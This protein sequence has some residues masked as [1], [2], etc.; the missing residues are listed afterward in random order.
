MLF[1]AIK[2]KTTKKTRLKFY[3]APQLVLSVNLII[4]ILTDETCLFCFIARD[5][6]QKRLNDGNLI[7]NIFIEF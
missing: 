6:S 4:F 7:E 1:F 2:K 5:I 3:Q